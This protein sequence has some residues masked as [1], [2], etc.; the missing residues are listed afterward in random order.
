MNVCLSTANTLAYPQGGHLWVF[1]NWALG[2]KAC[3]CDVVWLDVVPAEV[4]ADEAARKYHVLREELRPFG[5]D[6]AIAVDCFGDEDVTPALRKAGLPTLEERPPCELLVD[7]RYDLP[8]RLVR[9][10][11]RSVLVDLD[12]GQLQLALAQGKYA[13]PPHDVFF[14]VG[15]STGS[16]GVKGDRAW[17][18]TP[19]CVALDQW[20]V[21]A[22]GPDQPWTTVAHWWGGWMTDEQGNA[23]PDA[24]RD[25]FLPY[26]DV[27]SKVSARFELALNLGD[28]AAEKDMIESHGFKVLDAHEVAASPLDYRRFIQRSAGEFSCAKPSYVKLQTA[29]LSDRTVC[30]LASGKPCVIQSTGPSNVLPDDG[31]GLQRFTDFA[32]AVAGVERVVRDYPAHARAARALAEELFDAKRVAA[33]V[34]TVALG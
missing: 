33:R 21:A 25:G 22:G 2:L 13:A 4:S 8:R 15:E 34:L 6:A 20:P 24:K 17:L 18:H 5:L 32:G 31:M 1:I 27:P 12:P 3:G 10:H 9:R 14:S 30:Y 7:L 16:S 19:P 23:F 11:R 29:W 28:A 26:L